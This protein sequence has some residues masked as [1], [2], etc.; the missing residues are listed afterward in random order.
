ML[1]FV[2]TGCSTTGAEEQRRAPTASRAS[3]APPSAGTT[4]AP[5][6]RQDYEAAVRRTEACVAKS[7]VKQ[8]NY[9]WDPVGNDEM[10][11]LYKSP[12]MPTVKALEFAQ[13]CQADHLDAVRIG[14]QKS[15][16]QY[17]APELMKAVR[18][19]LKERDVP[20]T[21]LEKGP[22]DLIESVPQK[23]FT[24]LV[25]CVHSQ[26]SKLFPSVPIQFP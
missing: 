21:G 20:V 1:L 23:R 19:C 12:V 18:T 4:P 11:L 7:N 3:S 16:P 22:N 25:E 8:K 26:A 9:G 5:V 24:V 15:N 13:K 6:T 10:I 17:M 2:L 14:Y